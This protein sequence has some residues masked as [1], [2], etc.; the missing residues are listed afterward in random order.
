MTSHGRC[1]LL[2]PRTTHTSWWYHVRT[3]LDVSHFEDKQKFWLVFSD[4]E[5]EILKTK[6]SKIHFPTK[7][8]VIAEI[9]VFRRTQS[10]KVNTEYK[11]NICRN[12]LLWM[13]RTWASWLRTCGTSWLIQKCRRWGSGFTIWTNRCIKRLEKKSRDCLMIKTM[14]KLKMGLTNLEF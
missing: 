4:K 14:V 10:I 5:L 1:R 11:V 2:L 9:E 13:E 6:A 3:R 12:V 7:S 8:D